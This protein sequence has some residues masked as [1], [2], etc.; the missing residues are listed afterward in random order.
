MPQEYSQP[1]ADNRKFYMTEGP[2]SP[3]NKLYENET[4]IKWL[5]RHSNQM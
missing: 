1:D 2:I 3:T 5:M 4:D